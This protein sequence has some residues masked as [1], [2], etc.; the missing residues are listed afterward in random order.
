MSIS[1]TNKIIADW[2]SL[3]FIALTFT[4]CAANKTRDVLA[5]PPTPQILK[6]RAVLDGKNIA[7]Q[8]FDFDEVEIEGG[9]HEGLLQVRQIWNY[10]LS[11]DQ[12]TRLYH[13]AGKV[14]ALAFAAELGRQGLK[15]NLLHKS[16]P[17]PDQTSDFLLSGEVKRVILNTFGGGTLEGLGSAGN[18]WE[19]T[20]LFTGLQLKELST[21]RTIWQG[22]LEQYA[23]LEN[24]PA[25]LNWGN[26]TLVTKSIEGAFFLQ[27]VQ[28]SANL[29]DTISGGNRYIKHWQGDY[30]LQHYDVSP[31]EVAA[32]YAAIKF[33]RAIAGA[34]D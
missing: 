7:I 33:L 19:A 20:V 6:S 30:S 21:N 17:V 15:V 1:R 4:G 9:H 22:K 27:E 34:I 24:S 16:E 13:N 12:E 10:G 11:E 32:R 26:L 31:I 18:Y 2:L 3:F 14:A 8:L 5:T 25:R 23:K 29:V 28:A